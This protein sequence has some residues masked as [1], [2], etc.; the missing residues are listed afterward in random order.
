MGHNVLVHRVVGAEPVRLERVHAFHRGITPA[1]ISEIV[2]SDD[3]RFVAVGSAKGTVHLLD[4]S[5]GD[6]EAILCTRIHLGSIIL[7]EGL[8]PTC[9]FS[10]KGPTLLVTTRAG[11]LGAY[12]TQKKDFSAPQW[13]T[14]I[15]RAQQGFAEINYVPE[16]APATTPRWLSMVEAEPQDALTIWR[17]PQFSC[18]QYCESGTDLNRALRSGLRPQRQR[19]KLKPVAVGGNL[20]GDELS[21]QISGALASA[22]PIANPRE[23]AD[24]FIVTPADDVDGFFLAERV[25]GKKKS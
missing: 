4:L 23:L 16:S 10:G 1:L 2:V 21:E 7:Q 24:E 13:S 17:S 5:G 15:C 25:D 14:R 22:L 6:K 18:F 11:I 3:E 20:T 8:L 19:L 9:G 12:D